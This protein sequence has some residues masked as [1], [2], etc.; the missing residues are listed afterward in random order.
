MELILF[1]FNLLRNI[2]FCN[3]TIFPLLSFRSPHPHRLH[4]ELTVPPCQR[5]SQSVGT[6]PPD[7]P[8]CRMQTRSSDENSICPSVRLSVK[9]VNCDK[10]EEKSCSFCVY[11]V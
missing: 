1:F 4:S 2:F 3:F 10:T 9:S 8:R 11:S 7:L 6:V 5:H